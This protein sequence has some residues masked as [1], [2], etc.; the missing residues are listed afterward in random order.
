MP[1]SLKTYPRMSIESYMS[2]HEGLL[3]C[4]RSS[5]ACLQAWRRLLASSEYSAYSGDGLR[6]VV[7]IHGPGHRVLVSRR[8]FKVGGKPRSPWRNSLRAV[9]AARQTV[10]GAGR[11]LASAPCA[12]RWRSRRR[13]GPGSRMRAIRAAETEPISA[14][15]ICA[16]ACTSQPLLSIVSWPD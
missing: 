14:G 9:R 5:I 10:E 1:K 7:P 16:R 3:T 12:E 15:T 2:W 13:T 8:R 11:G 6:S 4:D